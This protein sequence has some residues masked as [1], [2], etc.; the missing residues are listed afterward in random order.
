MAKDPRTKLIDFF[1]SKASKKYT[2]ISSK[3]IRE[4]QSG[5]KNLGKAEELSLEW[6]RIIAE[7]CKVFPP[8][9]QRFSRK[10]H[11]KVA[12]AVDLLEGAYLDLA[13]IKEEEGKYRK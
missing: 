4:V 3:F 13:M 8:G 11:K 9:Y 2:E 7:N 5:F 12:R 10:T 1:N 6:K